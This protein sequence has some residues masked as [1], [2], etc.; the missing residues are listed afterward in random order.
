VPD[1]TR[2]IDHDARV[3]LDLIIVEDHRA[4]AVD[5]VVK[6]VGLLVVM[7][8]GVIDLDVVDLAGGPIFLLDERAD[9][10]AGLGP[11]LDL[12]RVAT[13]EL[14]GSIRTH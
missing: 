4:P 11:R 12:G 10:A 1:A 14:G 2:H 8:L 5:D 13:E 3:Q 9:L 6:L 7:E